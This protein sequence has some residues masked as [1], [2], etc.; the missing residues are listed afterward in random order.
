MFETFLA[1]M[2]LIIFL[3]PGFIW[4]TVEGQFVY[5]DRRL[6][7]NKLAL[8]L[9]TRSTL[10]YLPYAAL[11]YKA[12]TLKVYDTAP[13]T[14]GWVAAALLVVLPSS[15]GFFVGRIRQGQFTVQ[16]LTWLG[17]R[18]FAQHHVPTAWDAVFNN[19]PPSWIIVTLK[20]GKVIRGYLGPASHISSDADIRDIYI[21][22]LLLPDQSAFVPDTNGIYIKAD[23]ISSIELINYKEPP[24]EQVLQQDSLRGE[25]VSAS[26]SD[27]DVP[28]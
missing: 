7:W 28:A 2:L 21:S 1:V 12:W 14:V 23:E 13:I 19:V 8:G 15:L 10:L 18:T 6:E 25:H 26:A 3:V 4:R 22:H 9:L 20:N 11:L 16:C 17:I 5:L 24:H 27:A